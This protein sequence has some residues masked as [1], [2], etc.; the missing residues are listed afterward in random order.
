MKRMVMVIMVLLVAAAMAIADVDVLFETGTATSA[1]IGTD[2]YI[3]SAFVGIRAGFS[4]YGKSDIDQGL[5]LSFG[6]NVG[7]RYSFDNNLSVYGKIIGGYTNT[8]VTVGHLSTLAG[9]R[10][11]GYSTINAAFGFGVQYAFNSGILLMLG[12]EYGYAFYDEAQLPDGWFVENGYPYGYLN[13]VL[14]LGYRFRF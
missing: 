14:G 7:Y 1:G 11:G 3:G 5:P 10:D 6:V 8:V 9:Y 2:F 4:G 13:P 12:G